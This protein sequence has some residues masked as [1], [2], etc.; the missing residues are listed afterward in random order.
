MSTKEDLEYVNV[1]VSLAT[2]S[3]AD[4]FMS[5]AASAAILDTAA[6][7]ALVGAPHLRK[8]MRLWQAMGWNIISVKK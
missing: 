7:Q 6:A 5:I 4:S 3:V 8:K 2:V 1:D